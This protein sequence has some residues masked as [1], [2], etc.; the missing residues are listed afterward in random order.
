VYD[1]VKVGNNQ[2]GLPSGVIAAGDVFGEFIASIGDIDGDGI[3]DI[4]VGAQRDDDG[5]ITDSGAVYIM[6]MNSNRTAKGYQKISATEGGASMDPTLDGWLGSYPCRLDQP[7]GD[8]GH[9]PRLVVGEILG[10]VGTINTGR[11]WVLRLNVT[12]M[13]LHTQAIANGVGG[14]PFGTLGFDDFFGMS[15]ST[16]GGDIDRDGYNDILA[17]ARG[18]DPGGDDLSAL[19]VLFMHAND[20]VRTFTRISQAV[21]GGLVGLPSTVSFLGRG[22]AAIPPRSP[23]NPVDVAIG[24]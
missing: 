7:S 11:I 15:V 18:Q 10:D 16:D 14:L 6:F 9:L 1:A 13:V 21:G 20:T 12:G 2:G 4:A 22:M 17:A 19:Y 23:G 24:M 3:P 8:D 5:S